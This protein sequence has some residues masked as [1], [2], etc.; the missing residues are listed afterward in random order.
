M[1]PGQ[2]AGWWFSRWPLDALVGVAALPGARS[3]NGWR[4]HSARTSRAVCRWTPI[5]SARS[6]FWLPRSRS[7]VVCTFA[8][9]DIKVPGETAAELSL[10]APQGP[11]PIL[12]RSHGVLAPAFDRFLCARQFPTAVLLPISFLRIFRPL[13]K[14]KPVFSCLAFCRLRSAAVCSAVPRLCGSAALC[15]ACRA[16]ESLPC[17]SPPLRVRTPYFRLSPLLI[18]EIPHM[19]LSLHIHY[20]Q[21]PWV[22]ESVCGE[23]LANCGTIPPSF[24]AGESSLFCSGQAYAKRPPPQFRAATHA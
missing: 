8:A 3:K 9:R 2:F 21:G 5:C 20:R 18:A 17:W 16:S 11:I 13:G 7:P 12:C 14:A 1:S 23:A 6:F 24:W 10:K 22:E 15:S 4:P 19:F